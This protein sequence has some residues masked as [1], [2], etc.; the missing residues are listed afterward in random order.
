MGGTVARFCRESEAR[1]RGMVGGGQDGGKQ[2]GGLSIAKVNGTE[3]RPKGRAGLGLAL[4]RGS[5]LS[6]ALLADLS[7]ELSHL[8]GARPPLHLSLSLPPPPPPA[9]LPLLRPLGSCCWRGRDGLP[10]QRRSYYPPADPKGPPPL[11]PPALAPSTEGAAAAAHDLPFQ[12][13]GEV[14]PGRH[15]LTQP[16]AWVGRLLRETGR[17]SARARKNA[18]RL[19]PP[20][21]PVHLGAA[22]PKASPGEQ[23][24]LAWAGGGSVGRT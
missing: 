15:C 22:G 9:W 17:H 18:P 14:R 11:L 5:V 13:L 2:A 4:W 21:P 8:R 10:R 16:S 24:Q 23:P 12:H 20:P 7:A 1:P 6:L 3:A 19:S